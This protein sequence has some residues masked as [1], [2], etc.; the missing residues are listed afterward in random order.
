MPNKMSVQPAP[1]DAR[2]HYNLGITLKRLGE[3]SEAEACYKQAIALK[4]DHSEAFYN[5]GKTLKE[6]GRLDEATSSYQQ[7]IALK[8]SHAD[9]EYAEK[10]TKQKNSSMV[11]AR[12]WRYVKLG[13]IHSSCGV[14]SRTYYCYL[15]KKS[16]VLRSIQVV[17]NLFH[18]LL[19]S[20][21]KSIDIIRR[22][23]RHI[24]WENAEKVDS[25]LVGV[26]LFDS[27]KKIDSLEI[28]VLTRLTSPI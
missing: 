15:S 3:L 26:M 17:N 23:D 13:F 21:L 12:H 6:L 20:N 7:A 11:R 2:A 16:P 18:Q 8:P 10:P 27:C 22:L 4:R 1:N 14:A 25:G 5:L 9:V 24:N 28:M 19:S